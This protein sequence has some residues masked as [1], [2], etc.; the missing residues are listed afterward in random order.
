MSD[1]ILESLSVFF[2]CYN[3]EK[4]IESTFNKALPILQKVAKN[5]EI[6]LVNDGSKDNTLKILQKLKKA[7][8]QQVTIVN[9]T[10]NRGYGAAFK[11][12]VYT[13]KYPWITFTDADGQFDFNEIHKL[14]ATQ[15]KTNADLVIGF[16]NV[17]QV[18]AFRIWG[19]AAW[20]LAVFILFGLRV[21]DIDCGFKLFRKEVIDT[22]PHLEAE[23]GP[24]ISSEFLLKAKKKKFKIVEIGVTHFSRQAGNGTGANFDVVLAG[25]V[26]LLR[27]WF[28]VNFTKS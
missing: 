14:V 28:K 20:Q 16:Y 7:H 23:R 27:L 3:E 19:S 13:A 17:R 1:Y 6:I 11:S 10:Q 8:P 25:L 12:G 2:P 5:W 15:K 9:H 26:D 21:K 22:I 4:N 24:F 18:P